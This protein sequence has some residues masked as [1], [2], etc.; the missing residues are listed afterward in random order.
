MYPNQEVDRRQVVVNSPGERRETITET[1]QEGPSELSFSG[2]VIAIIA[3]MALIAIGLTYYVVSN[4]NAN[5]EANRQAALE[6][7][8]NN[9]AQSQQPSTAPAPAQQPVII[10]QPAAPQA[11]VIVTPPAA[12]VTQDKSSPLDDLTIQDAATKRLT[13][14]PSLASISVMVIDGRA[15]LMGT[16]NSSELKTKAE[17]IVKAVRGVKSVENKLEISNR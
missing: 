7:S 2:G 3:I 11:P 4:K 5:E 8:R 14:D 17:K 6:A 12:S 9:D 16:V 15:T 10:Q 13:D 1:K